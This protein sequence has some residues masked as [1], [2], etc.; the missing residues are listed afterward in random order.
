MASSAFGVVASGVSVTPKS[1]IVEFTVAKAP[2]IGVPETNTSLKKE[3]LA[4]K[5]K[6]LPCG[7]KVSVPPSVIA[8]AA[9]EGACVCVTWKVRRAL[10]DT[11]K[12]LTPE[13]LAVGAKVAP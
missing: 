7:A 5:A 12:A 13:V 4:A 11:V 1:E 8:F 9:I 2:W 6:R 3:G 10:G